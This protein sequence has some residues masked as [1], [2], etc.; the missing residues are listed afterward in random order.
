MLLHPPGALEP[1][2]TGPTP[3]TLIKNSP[4]AVSR[5]APYGWTR[6]PTPDHDAPGLHWDAFRCVGPGRGRLVL[7]DDTGWAH[8]LQHPDG[9]HTITYSRIRQHPTAQDHQQGHGIASRFQWGQF[10]AEAG[11]GS[12][13]QLGC[14]G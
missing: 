10:G 14:R 13:S 5:P 8:G 1:C 2:C 4:A 12:Q 6:L 11:Y 9:V 3:G 7:Q